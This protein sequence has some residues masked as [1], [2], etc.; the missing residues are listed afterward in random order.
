[1]DMG[2][3]LLICKLLFD[4]KSEFSLAA[5]YSKGW[6]TPGLKIFR[7]VWLEPSQLLLEGH[8]V[9]RARSALHLG[10]FNGVRTDTSNSEV[11]EARP[12]DALLCSLA[13]WPFQFA[14]H[15]AGDASELNAMPAMMSVERNCHG[16]FSF[17][18]PLV[19]HVLQPIRTSSIQSQKEFR[20]E[21][22][23]EQLLSCCVRW[24]RRRSYRLAVFQQRING[25]VHIT[26]LASAHLRLGQRVDDASQIGN[27]GFRVREILLPGMAASRPA[28]LSDHYRQDRFLHEVPRHRLAHS[29][30][31]ETPFRKMLEVPIFVRRQTRDQFRNPR[32]K[33]LVLHNDLFGKFLP[34]AQPACA[35]K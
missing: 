29:E 19:N 32:F 28:F 35:A 2:R 12:G 5:I 34:E 3:R 27:K 25:D 4:H 9:A 7:T 13:R 24:C 33:S 30:L 14:K 10:T 11:T 21:V 8:H 6:R 17:R 23:K 20:A 22:A 15:L 16:R 18:P 31:E 26:V 1:M